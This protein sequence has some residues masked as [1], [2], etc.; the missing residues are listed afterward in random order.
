MLG[1]HAPYR[2]LNGSEIGEVGDAIP[3]QGGDD[4]ATMQGVEYPVIWAAMRTLVWT[5]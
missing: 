3:V 1:R 4:K 2:F 5:E